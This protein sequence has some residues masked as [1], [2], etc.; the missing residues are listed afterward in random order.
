MSMSE[1]IDEEGIRVIAHRPGID[2]TRSSGNP[3]EV[4]RSPVEVEKRVLGEIP[5]EKSVRLKMEP[6][7]GGGIKP[8]E[9]Q[10]LKNE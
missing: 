3:R 2:I 8:A 4:L 5:I 7:P 9:N 6:N 1:G 10:E